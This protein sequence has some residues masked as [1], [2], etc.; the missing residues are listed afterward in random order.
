MRY[1]TTSAMVMACLSIGSAV[2]GPTPAHGHMHQHAHEKKEVEDA[3][4]WATVINWSTVNYGGGAS[5]AAPA[6]TSA[7]A[8]AADSPIVAAQK[9][10]TTTHAAAATSA[11]AS[12]G[13][14]SSSSSTGLM[15]GIVGAS[16]GRTAFGTAT[17]DKGTCPGIDCI[18]NVG[19]PYGS[20]IIK[21]SS[22][23]GYDYTNTFHNPQK[24]SIT[25]N[26]WNKAGPDGQ[27]NSGQALAPKSTTLTFV[28]APGASQIVA[29]Q[30][31]TSGGFCQATSNAATDGWFPTTWGEYTYLNGGS[32]FDVS[33]IQNPA[34][35]N[36]N[37]TMSSTEAACTSDMTKNMWVTAS[38][39]LGPTGQKESNGGDCV[40][41]GT[42]MH[43]VTTLAGT[44]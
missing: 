27:A 3:A 37:M 43:V 28:L 12:S 41:M 42:S 9:A 13:S 23:S 2:A 21:V 22:T 19:S 7:A 8:A 34:G 25:V 4:W 38:E 10:T 20:N 18:N 16:N 24:D 40:A 30:E 5:T 11:A 17:S 6:A 1:T 31:N 39:A 33:A 15:N 35:N 29:F 14:S 26:I 32:A 44:V 36:Y